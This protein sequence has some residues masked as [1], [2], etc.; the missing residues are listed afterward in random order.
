MFGSLRAVAFAASAVLALGS[1]SQAMGSEIGQLSLNMAAVPVAMTPEAL[2]PVVAASEAV[3]AGIAPGQTPIVPSQG[4]QVPFARVPVV[5]A[6]TLDN[7]ASLSELVDAHSAEETQS[8]DQEC[9]A[10]A[11]YF[12]A[13]GEP[14]EGQLAVAEVVLN[15]A[16]SGKYPSSICGVVK[17][18]AQFSFVR[19]GRIPPIAKATEAW[20]KA[21]A[22]TQVAVQ[23]LAKQMGSSVL[24]YHASY[25]SPD[26]GRRL[27]RVAQIGTHI[28]YN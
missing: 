24:W 22:I 16:A 15:R 11:V 28:F 7:P 9:I 2:A 4:I 1:A 6:P 27:T 25:V 20:R 3:V 21:V 12:E 26:W 19:K 13:R 8:E 5:S 10:A 18:R 23:H 17:Q 14:I